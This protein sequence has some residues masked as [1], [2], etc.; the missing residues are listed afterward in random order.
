MMKRLVF[1]I[2]SLAL[3]VGMGLATSAAIAGET[4]GQFRW[5][6]EGW[7]NVL[8]A[9]S[10]E[11]DGFGY[12]FMRTRV[13]HTADIGDRGMFNVSFENTRLMGFDWSDYYGYWWDYG[14]SRKGVMDGTGNSTVM[15]HEA[16]MGIRDFLFEGFDA[17]A[18]RF[19][20]AYGRERFIGREDWSWYTENR[21][22]GFKGHYVFEKGWF[23]LL[24]LKLEETLFIKYDEG[25]GDHDLRGIYFHYDAS[26][27]M[28]FEP[29]V[30]L[31]TGDNWGPEGNEVDNSSYF[32]FG[33]LFDYMH[34][35]GLHFYA[36]AT[37]M[38]GTER[39][40]PDPED[41]L[42]YSTMGAYAGLF[43][44]FDSTTKPFIGVEFNYASGTKDDDEEW[45]T[46]WS[47]FGSFSNYMGI[48]NMV[49]WQNTASFRFSGGL[50]PVE[51]TDL[52]L[53][54]YLFKL[55]QD[56]DSAYGYV[57]GLTF[58]PYEYGFAGSLPGEATDGKFGKSVGT[59][60]DFFV[61]HKIADGVKLN[62]G[63]S[64][65]SFGDYFGADN[66]LDSIMYAWLGGQVDF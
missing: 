56:E 53:D 4:Y 3:L 54:F 12:A 10:D 39:W 9:D 52:K 38:S 17:Y 19:S 20:L 51:G 7:K 44:E 6:W 49:A 31:W 27:N 43:Y 40:G 14:P 21:F 16:Y 37:M 1:L 59:E 61:K 2:L 32:I 65:F 55:A 8:D 47:P 62:G 15:V 58:E 30:M 18:G 42:D 24:C 66:K 26:E 13:G 48:Q 36:E 64:I 34:E 22:D 11:D 63:L 25:W 33:A 41:E 60:I 46:F 29:Y 57:N 50:T 5:R 35:N 28:Y 23:D 45:K